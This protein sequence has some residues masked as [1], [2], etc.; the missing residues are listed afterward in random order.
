MWAIALALVS[1]S[2]S[3]KPPEKGVIQS[4]ETA[5]LVAEAILKGIYG[6]AIIGEKP[7]IVKLSGDYWIIDGTMN[8]PKGSTV[9]RVFDGRGQY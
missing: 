8:C 2:A 3:A 7:F 9:D 4:A 6:D 1:L 5:A